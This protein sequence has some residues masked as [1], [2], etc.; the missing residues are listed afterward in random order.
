MLKKDKFT[1][2]FSTTLANSKKNQKIIICSILYLI[3]E[4][5]KLFNE[6]EK[7]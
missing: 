7:V 2:L 6:L 5:Y 3:L 1:I 4:Y